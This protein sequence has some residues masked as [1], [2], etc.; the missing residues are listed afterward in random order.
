MTE[1]SILPCP[2]CGCQPKIK[3]SKKAHCQLH[4]EPSQKVV[5]YCEWKDCQA[6]PMVEAGDIYNGIGDAIYKK[7]ATAEAI[8][9]WNIRFQFKE[10]ELLQLILDRYYQ[11]PVLMITDLE[12]DTI[13]KI[14]NILGKR[15]DK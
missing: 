15:K 7:E 3:L 12:V 14:E 5:V 1:Q 8:K 2:F 6:K 13:L 11:R 10:R 4:G 9:I